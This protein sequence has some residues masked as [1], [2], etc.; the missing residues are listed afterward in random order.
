MS[1]DAELKS[2]PRRELLSQRLYR[3][4]G[5]RISR[6]EYATGGRLPTE[7][8]LGQIYGVSRAVVREAISSLKADGMVRA[9]QGIGVF[10]LGVRSVP[11]PLT[12]AK[13]ASLKE[14]IDLLE[15]RAC[16]ECE[17]ASLAAT[18][19]TD[20]QL[21]EAA[22]AIDGMDKAVRGGQSA[23]DW[24]TRFHSSVA[25]MTG[26]P[27]FQ[28]LFDLFG[29]QLLPRTRFGVGISDVGAMREYLA[30]VNTEHRAILT[31]IARRDPDTARAAMR[32]HLSNVQGRLRTAH[33]AQK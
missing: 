13:L 8:E 4:L 12:P 26:N 9:Q 24:D 31:A 5:E 2:E 18:R 1:V 25:A 11:Y 10:V 22:T 15:L 32:M 20:V 33:A 21:D 17:A 23:G 30:R 19:R 14:A 6:G 3:D 29:E 28:I 16:V 7:K 27:Q